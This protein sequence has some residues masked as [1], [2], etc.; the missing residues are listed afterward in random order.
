MKQ[1]VMASAEIFA[2]IAKNL[3]DKYLF[4]LNKVQHHQT[5]FIKK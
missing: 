3:Q 4:L 5:T 2:R 1:S